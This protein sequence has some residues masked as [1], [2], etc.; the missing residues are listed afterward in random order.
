MIKMSDRGDKNLLDRFEKLFDLYENNRE[1]KLNFTEPFIVRIRQQGY[2]QFSKDFYIPFDALYTNAMKDAMS[3]LVK[4]RSIGGCNLGYLTHNEINL[5]YTG[6][7]PSNYDVLLS[8]MT[9]S[10]LVSW[11]SSMM[12]SYF[13]E[14]L[15]NQIDRQ[16]KE[17]GNRQEHQRLDLDI[18]KDALFKAEFKVN[19][20]NIPKKCIYDYL[21]LKSWNCVR[22]STVI[23]SLAVMTDKDRVGKKAIELEKILKDKGMD[24]NN[25]HWNYRYGVLCVKTK[26]NNKSKTEFVYLDKPLSQGGTNII[27]KNKKDILHLLNGQNLGNIKQ[28]NIL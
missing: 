20:F 5:V 8:S 15:L 4:N 28:L 16:E 22:N 17:N 21:Y 18:Y 11:I 7:N 3:R 13:N 26:E 1:L 14:A 19:A 2:K 23:A 10:Q 6:C 9:I 12:T 25:I 24:V 27:A